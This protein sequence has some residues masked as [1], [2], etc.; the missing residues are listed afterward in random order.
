MTKDGIRDNT[1]EKDDSGFQAEEDIEFD[2][3]GRVR[4]GNSEIK[5]CTDWLL[6]NGKSVT[7][8]KSL[9]FLG[10]V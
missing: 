6:Q 10:Y 9:T 8:H 1:S 4:N 2:D 5:F 3:A 7:P